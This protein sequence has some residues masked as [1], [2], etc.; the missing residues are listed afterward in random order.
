MSVSLLTKH[1]WDTQ[2]SNKFLGFN[3][4][5]AGLPVTS[6]AGISAAINNSSWSSVSHHLFLYA[7]ITT[8]VF[9]QIINEMCVSLTD[10]TYQFLQLLISTK[11]GFLISK[12]I[13]CSTLHNSP[14]N[15]L[16]C[17]PAT[18]AVTLFLTSIQLQ[19]GIFFT[20]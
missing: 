18:K 4:R 13:Y 1:D 20:P 2:N 11:Y 12:S 19:P 5:L 16:E 8:L 7:S 9:L 6:V 15:G 10:K 17:F 14:I 3:F